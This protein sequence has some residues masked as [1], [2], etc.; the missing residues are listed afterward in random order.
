MAVWHLLNGWTRW[1]LRRVPNKLEVPE[2]LVK[3]AELAQAMSSR[4]DAVEA[5]VR[6]A[7]YPDASQ[8]A[9]ILSRLDA[10]ETSIDK[11]KSA[12]ASSNSSTKLNKPKL[13]TSGEL[14]HVSAALERTKARLNR[15]TQLPDEVL[16]THSDLLKKLAQPRARTPAKVL[17]SGSFETAVAPPP[18]TRSV[19]P[20]RSPVP[21]PRYV[22]PSV[23]IKM[24]SQYSVPPQPMPR[25]SASRSVTPPRRSLTPTRHYST[26]AGT[27]T[28]P[29]QTVTSMLGGSH[30]SVA[31]NSARSSL[32]APVASPTNSFTSGFGSSVV[33]ERGRAPPSPRSEPVF[34]EQVQASGNSLRL[35][36]TPLG[37][38][39]GSLNVH[40]GGVQAEP[41]FASGI[42]T[43]S[44]TQVPT[45]NIRQA[46]RTGYG[47]WG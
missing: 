32:A 10:V 36:G 34:M 24:E 11:F 35:G 43:I 19:T 40:S 45:T 16:K 13:A 41:L 6:K 39:G 15:P 8:H 28:P 9:A 20:P 14:R 37:T 42:S 3:G 27:S 2:K 4:L 17:S 38:P 21:P 25:T 5:T 22:E 18:R 7:S 23:S 31:A 33:H 26:S 1:K 12:A 29:R 44:G 47:W 30:V 46:P